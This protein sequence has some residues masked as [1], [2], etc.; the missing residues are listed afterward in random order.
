M[1]LPKES[2]V[3]PSPHFVVELS[4]L[5]FSLPVAASSPKMY[6]NMLT[7]TVIRIKGIKT[8]IHDTTPNPLSHNMFNNIVTI[9]VTTPFINAVL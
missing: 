9:N 7:M 2:I 5:E 6:N 4:H 1:I 8:M 3:M